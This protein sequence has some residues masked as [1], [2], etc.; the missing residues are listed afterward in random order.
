MFAPSGEIATAGWLTRSPARP[1]PSGE[2]NV[3]PLFVDVITP[4][5]SW[6]VPLRSSD[7]AT[8][9]RLV[10]PAPVGA[11]LAMS[12]AGIVQVRAPAAP[13]I[14]GDPPTGSTWPIAAIVPITRGFS[15]LTPPSYER[16]S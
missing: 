16:A 1:K 2:P 7:Q 13:S 11:P 10:A 4:P 6:F 3:P 9:I 8:T 15:N 5:C 12:I 14:V